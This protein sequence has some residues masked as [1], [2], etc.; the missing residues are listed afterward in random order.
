MNYLFIYVIGQIF[1]YRSFLLIS[2]AAPAGTRS[3]PCFKQYNI[4]ANQS[5][6]ESHH[7]IFFDF[8]ESELSHLS[9]FSPLFFDALWVPPSLMFNV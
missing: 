1:M 2:E 3:C 4:L 9:Y 6:P 8:F 7:S 5:G